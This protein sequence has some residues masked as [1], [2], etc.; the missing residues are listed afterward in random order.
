ML[1]AAPATLGEAAVVEEK[2]TKAEAEDM[3]KKL[4]TA[5]ATVTLK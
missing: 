3:K 4:E 5:G 2:V 1:G